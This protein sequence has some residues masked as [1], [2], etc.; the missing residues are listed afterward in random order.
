LSSTA[1]MTGDTQAPFE[2]NSFE[3]RCIWGYDDRA[4]AVFPLLLWACLG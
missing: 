4:K 1:I 3:L 2:L